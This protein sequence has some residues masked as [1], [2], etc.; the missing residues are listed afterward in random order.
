LARKNIDTGAGLE[1]LACVSQNV[2]TNFD[3]DLFL[4]II[5]EIEKLTSFKYKIEAYF[6]KDTKQ[7]EINKNFKIIA[8]HFRA[9]VFAIADGAIPS[10]KDRG[11]IIRRLFRRSMICLK[12]LNI[13]QNF[14]RPIVIKIIEIMNDFYSYLSIHQEKIISVLENE[15]DSFTKTLNVGY[16]LFNKAINANSLDVPTIFKLVDTYGFPFELIQDLAKE[17]NIEINYDSYQKKMIEHQNISRKKTNEIGMAQQNVDLLNFKKTSI[18]SYDDL[19]MTASVIGLFNENFQQVET[20]TKK[21]W[22]VF[23]KTC[24]YATSGGQQHD[25][26][27]INIKNKRM[28]VL[29]V[30]KSPNL[31][32]LHLIYPND[33]KINIGDNA[34][35]QVDEKCRK[36][37][38]ANH[39]TEHLLQHALQTRID[40]NIKQKG[41]FKSLTRLTFDFEYTHKLTNDQITLI[42]NEINNYIKQKKLVTTKIM[43]LEQAKK[44][45]AL[46]YFEDVYVK[47]DNKLRVVDVDG[48]SKEICGGTHV[49]STNDIEQ[50]MITN[51]ENKGKNM[52]RIEAITSFE[53]INKFLISHIE[54]IKNEINKIFNEEPELI[55][56]FSNIDYSSTSANYRKL[57]LLLNEIKLKRDEL[58][59]N[60][61]KIEI[62]K[63]VI[64]I[65]QTSPKIYDDKHI[66]VINLENY[67]N[68]AIKSALTEL[69]SE[70]RKYGHLIL[71]KTNGR[72]QYFMI[73]NDQLF[74]EFGL[75][76]KNII[77]DI[78]K[79]VKGN[80]GGTNGFA[81]G[82]TNENFNIE[83][84]LV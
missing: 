34:N 73:V 77:Q 69:S 43:T 37:L 56:Q 21:G 66:S 12:N 44:E 18:F 81:Q 48:I 71:N 26:G 39:T 61:F 63:Q 30:I 79:Q 4:P 7:L 22:V 46:A 35:L 23:D 47:L 45:G 64:E 1:R 28:N 70:N 58:K 20:L 32:H 57:L 3:T 33:L 9:C 42:E 27:V 6:S 2:P 82:A 25:E 83:E 72:T 60:K 41:A 65:K 59:R 75:S 29:D 51:I 80:G 36:M 16:E 5:N 31:Q 49:K 13:L 8:D 84:W 10:A 40:V 62:A 76:A 55:N 50:F 19:K 67:S 11:S 38:C 53:Q 14:V 78:N 24:F 15:C 74:K 17:K 68:D 54:N 52:W